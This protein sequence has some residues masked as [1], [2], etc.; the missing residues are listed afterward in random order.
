MVPLALNYRI[1][2]SFDPQVIIFFSY[3]A[4]LKT[5]ASFLSFLGSLSFHR[6]AS[7]IQAENCLLETSCF[8]PE[9]DCISEELFVA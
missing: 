1:F 8:R 5:S 9:D 7:E 2:T 3:I 4:A 6:L